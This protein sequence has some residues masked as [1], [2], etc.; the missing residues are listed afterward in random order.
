MTWNKSFQIA[1]IKEDINTIDA[2]LEEIPE[3]KKIE[4][5]RTAYT[6]IGKVK[7]KFENKQLIIQHKMNSLQQAS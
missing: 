1:L 4:D 7:Q 5:M 6:L 2:L 3:F